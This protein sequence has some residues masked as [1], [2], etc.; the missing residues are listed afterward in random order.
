[1]KPDF[2]YSEVPYAFAHCFNTKCPRAAKCLRYLVTSYIPL[3]LT[4]VCVVNPALTASQEVEP[5]SFFIPDRMKRYASG[6]THLLDK[7]PHAEALVIK[8]EIYNFLGRIASKTMNVLLLLPSRSTFVRFSLIME[9]RK[10]LCMTRMWRSMIGSKI[11][12][13]ILGGNS[14]AFSQLF[15]PY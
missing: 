12:A 8:R 7:I 14:S 11:L 6:I 2:D 3:Q 1:M 15:S 10:N 9:S 5:C 13:T 4:V